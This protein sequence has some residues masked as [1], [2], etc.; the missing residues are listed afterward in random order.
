MP[1][2]M[3]VVASCRGKTLTQ[4]RL[5]LEARVG[6]GL[7]TPPSRDKT[8]QFYAL[9]KRNRSPLVHCSPPLFGARFDA[10]VKAS[11]QRSE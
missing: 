7:K 1:V 10:R 2:L 11:L 3:P 9:L 4:K 8:T 6:I 5:D